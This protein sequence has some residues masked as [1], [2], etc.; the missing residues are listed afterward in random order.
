MLVK[1]LI[2]TLT[3]KQLNQIH[4][5][6]LK[7]SKPHLLNALLGVLTN[8]PT[9]QNALVVY[10]QM[11]HHPTSH[12]HYTFTHALKASTL[13]HAHQKGLEIHAHVIKSGY[14]SD[15]FIQN[16]L[17]HFYVVANDIIS[18]CR[19]FDSISFPDVVSWTSIISGLSKCGFEEEAIVKFC[20]MNVKPN[21][22]TLV[23]VLSACSSL[24]ALKLGKAIHG[25]SLRNLDE[26][27]I[28]LDNVVLDFYVRCGSLGSAKY[29][30]VNM[31]KRDVVSWTT[32]V[33]GYAQRGFSEEA[34]RVFQEMVEGGEAQPNE[35]TI[36][37][38]LS[39]CS[40][41]GALS[42]GQWV[43]SYIEKRSDLPVEGNVGN[44]LINMY[45]KCGTAGMAIH[46][47]NK[48]LR[49]DIISWST[50]ISG[51][52]MNGHGM[53]ALQLF[54]LMLVHG[55]PP[56]D[57][58]F[59]GL[60]SACSHAGLVDRGLM[61]FEAMKNVYGIMPQVQH[62]ACMVD[63]YGRAGLLEEAEDFIR[64]MPVDADGPIWG[65]LLNAC[66]VHWN[67][68]MFERIR[69]CLLDTRGVSIGTFALLSNSF[70][71]SDRWEDAN[72]VRDEMRS[73]GLKKMAG[74]SWIEV[75]PSTHTLDKPDA[76]FAYAG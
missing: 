70:A 76:C 62:Y 16:S 75:N 69:Q 19:I 38:V 52:A 18:A 65:A 48:L 21:S 39:A 47:F 49:K 41:I 7:N 4:A 44:A 40:S 3:S 64:Q 23:S 15:I 67:E 8:S 45:V 34:V 68:K 71:S 25:Y 13:L 6:I 31:P 30:F 63:M 73:M 66:R 37:N 33:G 1:P 12:N 28:I 26:S 60:L 55:V 20:F 51:M 61:I 9:P 58:T 32:M 29:L 74:C 57:V 35:A 72:K 24:R 42:L 54:S 14:Y 22:T 59:I 11:L 2:P 27:N 36:V 43:H 46:I 10:N 56:D 17:L 53:H 5:Q 50:I